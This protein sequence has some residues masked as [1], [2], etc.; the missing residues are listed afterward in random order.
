MAKIRSVK[1]YIIIAIILVMFIPPFAKYQ[2]LRYKNRKLEERINALKTENTQLEKDKRK[3]ET[4]IV[5]VE[6]RARDK[7]GLVRKGEIIM[8]GAPKKK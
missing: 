8:R 4:D 2:E 5:Y 6:Q 1:L 7:M 3:L